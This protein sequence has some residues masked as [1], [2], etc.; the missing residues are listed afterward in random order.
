M[1]ENK[2]NRLNDLE[3]KP[4]TTQ[5]EVKFYLDGDDG[6]ELY[7]TLHL[8]SPPEIPREGEYIGVEF[9]VDDNGDEVF[10]SDGYI[11]AHDIGTDREYTHLKSHQLKIKRVNTSY[12][13]H[14]TDENYK[15]TTIKKMVILTDTLS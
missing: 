15:C 3:G 6:I 7:E 11:D 1:D 5:Y 12:R 8:D 9:I 2:Q 14:V 10:R 13:K 4:D